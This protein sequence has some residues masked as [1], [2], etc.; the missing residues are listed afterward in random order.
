ME[1]ALSGN[2]PG[3]GMMAALMRYPFTPAIAPSAQSQRREIGDLI[4]LLFRIVEQVRKLLAE[5]LDLRPDHVFAVLLPRI[6]LVVL[7]VILLGRIELL[8]LA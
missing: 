7:L 4:R 3:G 1:T 2:V 5:L 6:L 8:E